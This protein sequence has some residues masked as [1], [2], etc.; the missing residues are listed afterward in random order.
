MERREGTGQK[1]RKKGEIKG[2]TGWAKQKRK[3]LMRQEEDAAAAKPCPST[4]EN[5]SAAVLSTAP[6]ALHWRQTINSPLS[7]FGDE[8]KNREEGKNGRTRQEKREVADLK[9]KKNEMKRT[10][11]RL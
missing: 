11:K 9:E 4:G 6:P 10:K 5:L 2:G 1:K 8:K 7:C 3:K